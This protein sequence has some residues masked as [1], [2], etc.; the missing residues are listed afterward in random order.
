[1]RDAGLT[2]S[3]CHGRCASLRSFSAVWQNV[4][5]AFCC[6]W[7]S[8][9][10]ISTCSHEYQTCVMV[11]RKR[12]PMHTAEPKVWQGSRPRSLVRASGVRDSSGRSPLCGHRFVR[13]ICFASF[14]PISA[15]RFLSRCDL[16]GGC[17]LVRG[18]A[19]QVA[20][21][22]CDYAAEQL[23]ICEPAERAADGRLPA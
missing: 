9:G 10:Y 22:T 18:C 4:A 11:R 8:G 12:S 17:V 3:A 15:A 2:G 5:R 6:H 13:L 1:M 16:R 14:Q 19:G 21:L 7:Q 20:L 23:S